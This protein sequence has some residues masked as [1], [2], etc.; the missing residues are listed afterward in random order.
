MIY[1]GVREQLRE[2]LWAEAI[3]LCVGFDS[4][5]VKKKT[6]KST[7]QR[8]YTTNNDPDYVKNLKRFGGLGLVLK[9]GK[10]DEK[11]DQ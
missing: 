7:Y 9:L 5:L 4:I 10:K 11:Q 2:K 6:E 3:N 1:A 8:F